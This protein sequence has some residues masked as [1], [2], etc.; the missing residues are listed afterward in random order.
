MIKASAMKVTRQDAFQMLEAAL[1]KSISMNVAAS[2]AIVDEGGHLLAFGRSER[3]LL[4]TVEVAEVKART[5]VYFGTDTQNLPFD[6]PFTPALLSASSRPF[7]FIPGGVPIRRE[8]FVVG[9]IGVGGGV[10]AE[11]HAIAVAGSGLDLLGE[12]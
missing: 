12:K 9:G 11:D 7:A 8:G 4:A 3:A 6:K 2:V 1:E 10:A 5:A